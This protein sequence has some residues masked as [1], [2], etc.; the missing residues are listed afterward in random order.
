MDPIDKYIHSHRSH[1]AQSVHLIFPLLSISYTMKFLFTLATLNVNTYWLMGISSW[2]VI[3]TAS[4]HLLSLFL[5]NFITI[6]TYRVT[7]L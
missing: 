7:S 6:R 3:L 1:H 2:F 4:S 5:D